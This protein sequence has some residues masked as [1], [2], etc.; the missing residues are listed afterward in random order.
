MVQ[1]FAV[2]HEV[3]VDCVPHVRR[4]AD[5]GGREVRIV[6]SKQGHRDAGDRRD[7]FDLAEFAIGER[8]VARRELE[9]TSVASALEDVRPPGVVVASKVLVDVGD[10]PVP[11]CLVEVVLQE[12]PPV[13]A[14]VVLEEFVLVVVHRLKER[15]RTFRRRHPSAPVERIL[16]VGRLVVKNFVRLEADLVRRVSEEIRLDHV[17]VPRRFDLDELRREDVDLDRVA[18]RPDDRVEVLVARRLEHDLP[19]HVELITVDERRH[20]REQVE[21]RVVV[22]FHHV[23][24]SVGS[25]HNGF[26]RTDRRVA[27]E[28]SLDVAVDPLRAVVLESSILRAGVEAKRLR[29]D[30]A[31]VEHRRGVDVAAEVLDRLLLSLWCSRRGVGV[32]RSH[33]AGDERFAVLCLPSDEFLESFEH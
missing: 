30:R 9:R 29:S 7:R 21:D 10:H 25:R 15:R 26:S 4:E 22:D 14:G 18:G 3:R 19:E 11:L 5:L 27:L 16:R 32:G 13:R 2:A 31:G 6:R 23:A 24:A 17:L 8:Q 33:R 12:D 28:V 1:E 20:V